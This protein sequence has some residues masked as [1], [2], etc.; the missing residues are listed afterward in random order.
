M[1]VRITAPDV[2]EAVRDELAARVALANKSMQAYLREELDQLAS[3]P[4]I[5]RWLEQ[6]R[7]R[8]ATSRTHMPT[9]DI[10]RHLDAVRGRD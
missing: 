9:E 1:V 7:D 3:K 6:V 10:L 5:D 4:S 2:P 8:L